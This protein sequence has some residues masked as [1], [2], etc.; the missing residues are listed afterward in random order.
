MFDALKK[1]TLNQ[2]FIPDL[3]LFTDNNVIH[4]DMAMWQ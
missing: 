3:F 1:D 2:L 4:Y